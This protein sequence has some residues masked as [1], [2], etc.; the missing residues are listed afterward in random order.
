MSDKTQTPMDRLEAWVKTDH[1][2]RL[3]TLM[4]DDPSWSVELNDIEAR[5]PHEGYGGTLDSAILDALE[6][7]E[8]S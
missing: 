2:N 8:E 7:V 4:F 3:V 6:K 1:H 5:S